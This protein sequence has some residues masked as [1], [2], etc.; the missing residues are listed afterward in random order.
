MRRILIGIVII[1]ML[2]GMAGAARYPGGFFSGDVD[3]Y[4]HNITN[5]TSLSTGDVTAS[6]NLDVTGILTSGSA[7]VAGVI[8]DPLWIDEAFQV[9]GTA[10]LNATEVT[11]LV[12]SGDSY[13]NGT[14]IGSTDTLAV[15]TADKLTVGGNIIPQEIAIPFTYTA[16][17]VD[18]GVFS[19]KGAWN[20][21]AVELVPSVVG[22]DAGAVNVTVRVCDSGESP[23]S[24]VAALSAVL[25]LK[26][27][28][29]T[30]QAGSLSA[31]VG[32]TDAQYIALDFT[33][34]LTNAVGSGT[35]W[36]KR[37]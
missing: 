1:A 2:F 23:A 6:G 30:T 3:M 10:G 37:V 9:S 16:S 7:V 19:A 8:S 21:T 18:T 25:D 11:T 27:T 22:G 14:T 28:A 33:G 31:D 17:S 13:L 26:G 5:T 29:D 24:G 15:T 35:I 36:V 34:T 12:A 4:G 32:C 20:I